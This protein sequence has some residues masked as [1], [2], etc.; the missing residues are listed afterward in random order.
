MYKNVMLYKKTSRYSK[1]FL[2]V[3]VNVKISDSAIK[4][5]RRENMKKRMVYASQAGAVLDSNVLTGGGTDD[6]AA[7]QAVLDI[8]KDGTE[9]VYLVM[10]GA[11]LVR[12]LKVY[13]NTT[14]CCLDDT[15][16]FFM[17]PHSGGPLIQ[18]G[19]RVFN[20]DGIDCYIT[21]QGGTYNQN[22]PEQERMILYDDATTGFSTYI[23]EEGKSSDWTVAF[24]FIGVRHV[25]ITDVTIRD[26][27]VYAAFFRNWRH[28]LCE[29]VFIDLPNKAHGTN[30]DGLHFHGPGQYLTLRNIRGSSSDDFIA[31]GPDEE[32]RNAS[33]SD[34]LID[35]VELYGADQAIRML[36][37]SGG[38]LDRVTVKNVTGV[39]RSYGFFI[40]PFFNEGV[41]PGCG[42]GSIV[43]DTVNLKSE[44]IDYHYTE[45]F[46]FR[47]GGHVECL[48]L[49]NIQHSHPRDSR[50]LVDVGLR[51]CEDNR[52]PPEWDPET[53]V[54]SLVIDGI[55]TYEDD[56]SSSPT[57]Y[58]RVHSGSVQ[59]LTV[60]NINIIRKNTC[61]CG[62]AVVHICNDAKVKNLNIGDVYAVSAVLTDD[63]E[64]TG[65]VKMNNICLV[66]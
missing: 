26:Q 44:A 4:R 48:T 20:G 47:V 34:V 65:L 16:G 18:N 43:I 13:S 38:R 15:C 64:N 30:Q 62:G 61:G 28:V 23:A 50:Y 51:Y 54:D 66:K 49:R 10:D 12:G 14:I 19:N 31:L 1:N 59:S 8:A 57:E 33:I 35:G 2:L 9:G 24:L 58:V 27:C 60:K 46:L 63:S 7:I 25:R 53:K 6:T 22:C 11:A 40:N 39:Y 41:K 21:L 32:D 3:C 45:P 52:L 17:A 56:S 55:N 36:C 29:N 5:K 42:Y 37:C